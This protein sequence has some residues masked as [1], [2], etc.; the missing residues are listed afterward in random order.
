MP[1][2]RD[3]TGQFPRE[4]LNAGLPW[5][6]FTFSL[7]LFAASF[8]IYLGL[9]FGYKAF[10]NKS[11]D[12]LNSTLNSLS[13]QVAPTERD[14]FINFY[15]QLSN[16]QKLLASHVMSSKIFPLLEGY[17]DPRVAYSTVN[18]SVIDRTLTLDGFAKDYSVLA[19]QLATYQQSP[20]VESVT[21]EN[22]T[23]SGTTVRFTAKLILKNEIFHL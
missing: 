3:T 19:T 1:Y 4:R 21:L 20:E 22:S 14:G 9:N 7:I 13:F 15:S 2:T 16:L 12:S 23:L 10:L 11:I 5:R 18:I 17:T 6:L 8:V